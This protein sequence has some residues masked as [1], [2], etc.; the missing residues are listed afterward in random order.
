MQLILKQ[1]VLAASVCRARAAPDEF[2]SALELHEIADEAIP[3]GHLDYRT[4]RRVILGPPTVRAADRVH[5][6][7][8]QNLL[9]PNNDLALIRQTHTIHDLVASQCRYVLGSRDLRDDRI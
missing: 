2:E 3:A 7:L 9:F 8:V 4:G 1:S 5:A 6:N